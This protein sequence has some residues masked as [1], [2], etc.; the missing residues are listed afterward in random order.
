MEGKWHSV[1]VD[2]FPPEEGQYLVTIEGGLEAIEGLELGIGERGLAIAQY[3]GCR[4]WGL[5]EGVYRVIAW[6]YLP[7]EFEDDKR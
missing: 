2:G 6:M 3:Y 7:E 5:R 1:K 4:A